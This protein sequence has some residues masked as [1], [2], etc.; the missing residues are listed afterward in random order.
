MSAR[1]PCGS[2]REIEANRDQARIIG[3]Y[4]EIVNFLNWRLRCKMEQEP[5]TLDARKLLYDAEKA[6]DQADLER[7]RELFELAWDRWADVFQRYPEFLEDVEGEI[8]VESVI[9]Y[10][11]LLDQL[12]ETFPP[13]GFKLLA[14]CKAHE[15]EYPIIAPPADA[16][17]EETETAREPAADPPTPPAEQVDAS[18]S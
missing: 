3:R 4:R 6:F 8:V 17:I 1:E 15:I 5:N 14:L 7:S 2:R 9:R 18:P 16:V 12:G 13:P 10:K 11:R